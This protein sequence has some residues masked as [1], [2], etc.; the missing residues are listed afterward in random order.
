MLFVNSFRLASAI[1]LVLPGMLSVAV[2]LR[3]LQ[4]VIAYVPSLFAEG[5]VCGGSRTG[6]CF[7]TSIGHQPTNVCAVPEMQLRPQIRPVVPKA[8]RCPTVKM[9]LAR[10]AAA[11]TA[12]QRRMVRINVHQPPLMCFCSC[13]HHD[14]N[15]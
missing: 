2:A 6:T 1:I 8:K 14:N 3:F 4:F 11:R 13:I 15:G 7:P 10:R 5:P 12:L 9:D